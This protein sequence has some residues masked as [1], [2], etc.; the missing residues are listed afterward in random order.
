MARAGLPAGE[1]AAFLDECFQLQ[2][3]ALRATAPTTANTETTDAVQAEL[4]ETPPG[5]PETGEIRS[6]DLILLTLDY[7]APCSP[8]TRAPAYRLGDWLTVWIGDE[9]SRVGQI[10]HI[11]PSS[12]RVLLLNPDDRV[13]VA[14]HP[15]IL[16][17]QLREGAAEIRSGHSLFDQAAQ[18]A[19]GQAG[20]SP[21]SS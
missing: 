19:L 2:T 21:G 18:R 9:G 16:D 20:T 7:P 17:R 15:T 1:Q 8:P 12:R 3:Q 6:G 11:S 5:Q 4:P 13:T 14:V 10:C